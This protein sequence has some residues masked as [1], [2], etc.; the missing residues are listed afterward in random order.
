M[1][2]VKRSATLRGMAITAGL[3]FAALLAFSACGGGKEKVAVADAKDTGDSIADLDAR[4]GKDGTM[5]DAAR[6]DVGGELCV[7][8]CG[9]KE[10]GPDGCGGE[11]GQCPAAAPECK[12]GYCTVPCSPD[13]EGK[14]C[15]PDGCGG[16]CGKCPAA[17]PYCVD[18]ACSV[19]CTPDCEGKQCGPDGCGGSCGWCGAQELCSDGLCVCQPDC[20]A[21]ECGSD[22]CGGSCGLCPAEKP[23]CDGHFCTDDCQPDC[24][25]KECGDDGCGGGC[26]E[27]TTPQEKCQEGQCVCVP[28]CGQK[29]CGDDG[30]GGSCGTCQAGSTCI[31]G[32]CMGGCPAAEKAGTHLGC[33]F[34]AVDL[35]NVEGGQYQP[36][37]V[38]VIAP[39]GN[40]APAIVEIVNFAETPPAV[41][42]PETLMVDDMGVAPGKAKYF[43]LPTQYGI[44]GTVL[45]NKTFRVKS[46]Q[47]VG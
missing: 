21:K 31:G 18:S 2:S 47:P 30:C 19:D 27:C 13:C 36:V 4:G 9:D 3:S 24:A 29:E 10:C 35:D 42:S 1:G 38:V 34:F 25:G 20:A 7:P 37:A 22:E 12:G 33:E 43:M 14:E 26:G 15:G 8:K 46:T 16:E 5:P 32:K 11:C 17:A 6:V 44:D 28:I 39:S 45:T 41:L 23:F 40:I